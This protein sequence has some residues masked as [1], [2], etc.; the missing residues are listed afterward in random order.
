M[1]GKPMEVLWADPAKRDD[2]QPKHFAR[3]VGWS[4]RQLEGRL[5]PA[6]A[7]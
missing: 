5:S 2:P 1:W 6:L 3:V 7:D 4:D